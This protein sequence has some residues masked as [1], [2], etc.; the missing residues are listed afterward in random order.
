VIFTGADCSMLVDFIAD[1][2]VTAKQTYFTSL[3]ACFQVIFI[4]CIR[5]NLRAAICFK[6]TIYSYFLQKHLRV[7]I[8]FQLVF[9][10]CRR[11]GF[12]FIHI[13]CLPLLT[14]QASLFRVLG[15]TSPEFKAGIAIKCRTRRTSY[16]RNCSVIADEA[17][18]WLNP[19]AVLVNVLKRNTSNKNLV[20]RVLIMEFFLF[21]IVI[22]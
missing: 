12:I 11:C 7:D 21:F 5:Y 16:W 13:K 18:E 15:F 6:R 20:A 17:L 9:G 14:F 3:R 1:K 10:C 2:I 22:F 8:W 19:F 4:F